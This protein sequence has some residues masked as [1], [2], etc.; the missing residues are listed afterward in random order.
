MVARLAS[1]L[2]VIPDR[3]EKMLGR[4]A[5]RGQEGSNSLFRSSTLVGIRHRRFLACDD[6]CM[7]SWVVKGERKKDLSPGFRRPPEDY[8]EEFDVE[9]FHLTVTMCPVALKTNKTCEFDS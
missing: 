3:Y 8:I 1:L 5:E 6:G 2:L 9:T 4:S 7:Q